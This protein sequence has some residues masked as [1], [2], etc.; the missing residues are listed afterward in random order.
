MAEL[1]AKTAA[2]V[3]V[4]EDLTVLLDWLNIE[5]VSGFTIIVENAGGGSGNDITDVQVDTS[6]DGGVTVDTDQHPGVPTV[7]IAFGESGN[8][9]IGTFAETAAFVRVRAKCAAGADTTA[10]AM[11]TADSAAGRICTLSDVKDRLGLSGTDHDQAIERIISGLAAIFEGYAH[12]ILLVNAAET[13][14]YYTG[15]GTRLQLKRY[16]VVSIASVRQAYDYDFDSADA[17]DADTDYRLITAN[18]ILYRINAFWPEVEQ[19]IQ[20]IYRGGYCSAGQ[21]PGEGEFAM[22]ADLREAA[23]EQSCFLFKR[24]DDIGLSGVS[25]EGGSI[26][27]FSP[28]DLLP[29][30]KKILDSYRRPML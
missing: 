23:I 9:N 24:R 7:P 1:L 15:L 16:P 14:E 11:L 6:V 27:K 25:A 10:T 19:G 8:A 4:D 21:T 29:M 30:V 28:M 22:P 12:R 5:S 17:L 13:T 3:A 2:A 26:S 18:G 20:V